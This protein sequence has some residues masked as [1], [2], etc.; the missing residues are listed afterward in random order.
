MAEIAGSGAAQH[1]GLTVREADVPDVPE[2]I[3]LRH[4][5]F[6]EMADAGVAGRPEVVD[7]ASWY[8]AGAATLTNQ[9]RAGALRA[10][11]VEVAAGGHLIA[12]AV[13]TLEQR[14]PGP[15]FPTGRSGS[16]SSVFVEHGYRGQGWA[17]AVVTAAIGW[18]DTAGVEITDLHATPAAAPLYR[19]LEFTEPKSAPLRRLPPR[20]EQ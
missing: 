5:M 9:L 2:L 3:R 14:L 15:G 20:V 1:Q 4:A 16:M 18:L 12:C 13:A 7:D 11:V 10:F 8:A 17:R 6:R 19:S